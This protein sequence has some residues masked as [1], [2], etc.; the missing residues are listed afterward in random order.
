MEYKKN[1]KAKAKPSRVMYR[2]GK[3][4]DRKGKETSV[5]NKYVIETVASL[6]YIR[7]N[8]DDKVSFLKDKGYDKG[9]IDI[10]EDLPQ[11][12]G[13]SQVKSLDG[14]RY[15][16]AEE[17]SDG[18]P[19]IAYNSRAG[20]EFINKEGNTVRQSPSTGLFHEFVHGFRDI[21]EGYSK[22]NESGLIDFSKMDT[23]ENMITVG[24]EAEYVKKKGEGAR[25]KH[26]L[27]TFK[28]YRTKGPNTVEPE[29]KIKK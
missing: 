29:K 28:Y 6:N 3:L 27:K 5:D 8:G 24:P 1:G 22:Y 7:E 4:Y 14:D 15:I 12:I 23:E 21:F 13:I 19:K 26:K 20:L 11:E 9:L 2:D 16:P 10:M 25:Q 18:K 17:S